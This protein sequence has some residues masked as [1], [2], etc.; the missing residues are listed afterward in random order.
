M[1]YWMAACLIPGLCLGQPAFR[2]DVHLINISFSVRDRQGK[3]VDGLT[4]DDFEVLED[5]V[6]QKIS[7]FARSQDVPLTLGLVVDVS[8]SQ[9]SFVKPHE[10]DL[11]TFLRSALTPQDRAFLVCFA[12]H[13][14][15]VADY[16]TPGADLAKA[17]AGFDHVK[18]ATAYPELGPKEIRTAGTAF[19]DAIYY[20]TVQML[21]N[22][23][24]GRKALIVFSDG[25]DNSSAHHMLD[26][27]EAAQTNNALL[28]C[29]RYTEVKNE[30]L[31]SRNKYGMSVMARIAKET[32]GADF[33]AREH[34]L[35]ENFKEIGEQLRSA[36]ELAY[37]STN[38][39]T[40]SD[41]TF[42]KISIR[43][44]DPNLT[45]RAK[46]GYYAR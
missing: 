13:L 21:A 17:L 25:E 2:A 29:V 19:Y 27:I 9:D 18:D 10:K 7:F 20:S 32:G 15:L 5:G 35:A 26:A 6:A 39:D 24:G 33:D 45:V 34:G 30:R 31:T 8:G 4:Q 22:T 38:T 40:A 16:S 43:A 11:R 36:Y 12:N 41:D 28:F 3:L 46:T 42:H 23:E 44:K 1:K 14:R 37:H